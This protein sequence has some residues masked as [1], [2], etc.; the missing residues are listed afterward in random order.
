MAIEKTYMISNLYLKFSELKLVDGVDAPFS[1]IY[2]ATSSSILTE[3][4]SPEDIINADEEDLLEFIAAKSKNRISD[5]SRTAQLLKK[6]ARDSYRLDEC[7]YK[8]LTISLASSFNCIEAYR[9]EIKA[10]D[11]AIE[12]TIKG[13]SPNGFTVLLSIPGIGPVLATGI[14]AEIGSI[15]AFKLGDSL[16]KY[17]GLTWIRNQS[18]KFEAD[19]TRMSKAG[20]SYL[21]YFP[22]ESANSVRRHIPEYAGYYR[23]KYNE[24]TTHNHKRS[25]A[26]TSRKLVRLVFGLLAKNKLYNGEPDNNQIN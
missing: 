19:D 22:G 17:A 12:R 8:P 24:V 1:N 21:R 6:A 15:S 3:F 11:N 25:L 23:N 7:L 2:G 4:I 20:N 9:K 13:V 18:R 5:L 26:H 14:L 10:I 16:A